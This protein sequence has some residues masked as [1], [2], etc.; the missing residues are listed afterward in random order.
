MN[1]QRKSIYKFRLDVLRADRDALHEICLDSLESVV[2][3]LIDH[4]CNENL[5][6]ERWNVE[7]LVEAIGKGF[8]VKIDFSDINRV[9]DFYLRRAYFKL[10]EA[11]EAKRDEVESF[12]EE[13]MTS[14]EKNLF[15][16]MVDEQ[17][18]RHLQTMDQ[19]RSGIGLRGYGQRDPKKEYQ[20]EGFIL[21]TALMNSIRT[22]V[23]GQL[24]LMQIQTEE[25]ARAEEEA[26]RQRIE[27]EERRRR[28]LEER[29]QRARKL[30]EERERSAQGGPSPDEILAKPKPV[31]RERPRL[32]RNQQCWCGSGKK[33]K[34]CHFNADQKTG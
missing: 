30:L 25:E 22:Q 3:N 14:M 19:L 23:L 15:L 6:A 13:A 8:G 33:Y 4:F 2:R 12:Q 7:G 26:F 28:Q 31:T 24:F 27:Q 21:F 11:F 18:K 29:Q 34:K 9:H 32:G 20:R 17:W 5:S 10:Q 16:N 1:Q